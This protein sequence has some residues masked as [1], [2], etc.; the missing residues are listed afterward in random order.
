MS[1]ASA[2]IAEVAEFSLSLRRHSDDTGYL[3]IT[4]NISVV[5]PTQYIL[6]LDTSGSMSCP[7][8]T[9]TADSA[10]FSRAD[11]VRHSVATQ[12]ELMRPEDSL[13]IVLFNTNAQTILEPTTDRA[14]ARRE[15]PRI[16]ASGGTN[17]WSG[18]HAA[19]Q[20]AERTPATRSVII[21][22]TDG[23]S[24][25][26]LNPPRGI[27]D[28]L[29]TWLTAHP[30]VRPTIHT[31]GY[32]YG[33]ALDMPLLRRIAHIG[34]GT[35]NYI[36]DGGMVG[37]V[38]I[39]LLANL[40]TVTH[41]CVS[42][43]VSPDFGQRI[44]PLQLGQTRVFQVPLSA[45]IEELKVTVNDTPYT[46][47]VGDIDDNLYPILRDQTIDTIGR[48]LAPGGRSHERVARLHASIPDTTPILSAMRN[49]LIHDSPHK[50]QIGKA[51]ETPAAF[52]RWGQHYLSCVLSSLQNEWAINFKDEISAMFAERIR[53]LVARGDTIF[54]SL[55]P[56]VPSLAPSRRVDMTTI[57]SA[58]GVCFLP[59][60]R[61]LM[62]DSSWKR[63]DAIQPGDRV[64]G[65]SRVTCVLR[66]LVSS[67][68]IVR[69]TG[70]LGVYSPDYEAGGFT[71]WHP[72]MHNGN[73][74]FPADIGTVE[75]VAV[76]VLYNFVL[77]DCHSIIV[78]GV[79]TC[80]L[81]HGYSAPVVKHPYFGE[82]G[83]NSIVEDLRNSAGWASG[84]VTWADT[85]AHRDPD[86][87]M[88]TRMTYRE[89]F[90]A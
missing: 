85:R 17:I 16:N 50:G 52:E 71:L 43:S 84:V 36:P 42:I 74:T 14:A 86:T 1:A 83:R 72:V 57:H 64:A 69:L 5:P 38:F 9:V 87:G 7:S 15:L 20:H 68:Q 31:V 88:V 13:G 76:D 80:T 70:P 33:S 79:H 39:H 62:A 59:S 35:V 89:V 40:M 30:D 51:V 22:Q 6:V 53:D 61:V 65:N 60:S 23:E 48:L 32:G 47:G 19:L 82:Q 45:A 46:V 34:N 75:E 2:A 63:C 73:W 90:T 12:I 44:G 78:D 37:T 26:N 58:D 18:L 54:T 29:Q 10:A 67:A 66:T 28:T 8:S 81:G 3:S 4:S 56:P 25:P 21:L 11:L 55:P 77:D 41:P 24:D 27:A 49:D